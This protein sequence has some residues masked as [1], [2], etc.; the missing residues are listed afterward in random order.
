MPKTKRRTCAKKTYG[1]LP[2]LLHPKK[3]KGKKANWEF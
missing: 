1:K 2:D 3:H